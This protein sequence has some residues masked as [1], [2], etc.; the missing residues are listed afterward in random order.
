MTRCQVT[1][2]GTPHIVRGYFEEHKPGT[3]GT[4]FASPLGS[5]LSENTE[6]MI[7]EVKKISH[8]QGGVF[9]ICEI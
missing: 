4:V 1:I 2:N 9:L 6:A 3:I 8:A 5:K 7:T